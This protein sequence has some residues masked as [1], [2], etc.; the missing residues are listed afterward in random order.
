MTQM[1]QSTSQPN[2]SVGQSTPARQ[3]YLTNSFTPAMLMSIGST[4]RFDEISKEEFC[5]AVSNTI[6]ANVINAIGHE[7][8]VSLVNS[9]CN[10]N[11]KVNR[12]AIKAKPGDQIYVFT[13]MVR[14]EEGKILS[15]Q[16]IQQMY[17][18]G[19]IKFIKSRVYSNDLYNTI[20]ELAKFYGDLSDVIEQ[21]VECAQGAC[22]E[23]Q[24]DYLANLAKS[25]LEEKDD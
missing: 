14:L 3:I 7:S 6:N 4:V 9:L 20:E 25:K 8:T 17:N 5:N 2:Q 19:K 10:T 11:L 12:I 15:T 1:S 22:D 24:Y 16:E 21:L 18:E 13:V 23:R